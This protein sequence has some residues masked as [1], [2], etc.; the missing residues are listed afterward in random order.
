[1]LGVLVEEADGQKCNAAG[2]ICNMVAGYFKAK[3]G[4]GDACKLSVP[5]V[6]AGKDYKIRSP[7]KDERLEVPVVYEGEPIWLALDVRP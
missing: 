3:I 4:L 6:I 5:T 1:M 2:E 7:G